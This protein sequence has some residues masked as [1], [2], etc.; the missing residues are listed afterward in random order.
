MTLNLMQQLPFG[1]GQELREADPYREAERPFTAPVRPLRLL[2]YVH[3]RNIYAST[4]AGRV[5]RQMTEHLAMREDISL[6]VL[7]DAGDQSRI[8][9]LVGEPWKSFRYHTFASDTSRQQ[10]LWFALNRPKAESFWP[11]AD[12]IFCT[13]ESFVPTTKARLVVTAHDAAYFEPG[14]HRQNAAFWRQ[15]IKWALLF[16]RLVARADMVHTVSQFS[17]DRLAFH[18][19]A[20]RSR[21]RVVHN[22]VTP[23]F[24]EQPSVAGRAYV[25]EQGLLDRP[26][27]L[28]PGGLHF[29]KN[30]DLILRAAPR[31]LDRYPDL[32]LAVVNHSNPVYA[33]QA[34]ALGPRLRLLGFVDEA[35][36]QAL[37]ATT[38]AVWF[39]SLYEGFGLPVLEAMASGAPVVASDASSLPEI[40]GDAALLA[41]PVDTDDHLEKLFALLDDPRLQTTL[42][43][44]GR[45]RAQ[46]FT[47][48]R[49][50]AQLKHHFDTLLA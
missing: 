48:K 47:W 20:L 30:A 14:A 31:L 3:L 27:L 24:F 15:R 4:G 6:R 9:P 10:A 22:A 49:S 36:L 40:A 38:T 32:V 11:E 35:A 28:V 50:A 5:A 12:I 17:A 29:R 41:N 37:Y 19:P 25:R 8:L 7:A 23:H 39:P 45:H 43:E 34:A 18:F 13:G 44:R 21:L 1:E 33:K 16:R 46:Q 2:A 42:R 26:F